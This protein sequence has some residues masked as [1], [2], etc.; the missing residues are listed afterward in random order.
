MHQSPKPPSMNRSCS[1]TTL[2]GYASVLLMTLWIG[3]CSVQVADS[4]L[5]KGARS[6]WIWSEDQ[7]RQ[8]VF[9]VA[10]EQVTLHVKFSYNVVASTQIFRVTWFEPSGKPYVAGGVRTIFGNNDSLIVSL[11]IAGTT[12]QQKPGRW[13]VKVHYGAEQIV[14]R[15]FDLIEL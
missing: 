1:R 13:R 11:K 2:L 6:Y 10:D 14:S 5:S 3:G 7:P 12:A 8:N 15:R 4:V 9:S